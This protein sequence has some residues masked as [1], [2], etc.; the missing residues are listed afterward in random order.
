MKSPDTLTRWF[1]QGGEDAEYAT[2]M[3]DIKGAEREKTEQYPLLAMSDLTLDPKP[4]ATG[5]YGQVT[6]HV[7]AAH[8]LR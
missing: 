2:L 4:L 7:F 5:A 8:V 3:A 6:R 1:D